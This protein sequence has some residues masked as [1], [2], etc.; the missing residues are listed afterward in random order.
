MVDSVLLEFM[1]IGILGIGSQW[2]SWRFRLPAIVVMSIAGLLAGPIFGLINPE[3]DFGDLYRPIISVAVAI[4]LFEGSLSL[5]FKEVRGLGRPVFRIVT[6]GALISWLLGSFA[7]HYVAGLS[8]AVAYVI[9]AIFIVTGPTVILPLLRQSK[10]KPRPAKILKW[11]GVIVDPFGALLAV[12]AFETILF[13]TSE[14]PDGTAFLLFFLAS[15]FAILLGL[16]FGKGTGWMFEAGYIPEFLKSPAVFAAVIACFTISDEIRHETGLLAVTAMGITLANMGISSI[17]DMRHF[18]ENI[19]IL[20][21]STIFIML[22]ASLTRDTLLDILNF[23]IIGYVLLMLF[24]VRP[25]SIF[26]STIGTDLTLKEKVLVGWIAPRGIVALTVAGYFASVLWEEGFED[27]RIVTSLTFALV[28]F[29]VCAHGFS[30][31]WLARKLDLSSEG[32]PGVLI[33]GSN[34]F[35][36]NLAK[37]FEELRVPTIITDSSW[38]RLATARRA[39]VN[40][41]HGEILSEQTEYHLDMTPYD[42][43]ISAT[44]YDSYNALVCTT[45]IPAFG[46]K[47]VFRLG[48]Q[49]ETG[50][51]VKEMVYTIGGRVLFAKNVALEDLI[52]KI[53][54][55]YV[56]RKTTITEQYNYDDYIK[57]RDDQAILLFIVKASKKIE[58]FIE[59]ITARAEQGDTVVSLTPPSKEFGKIQSKLKQQRNETNR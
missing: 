54:G 19:S 37:L 28:F 6:F 34:K 13:F 17:K 43:L 18:K 30:I 11:E 31:G 42:Y 7:A 20:L 44:E 52:Q 45:F 16:I 46:R 36:V 1:I 25:L 12:F 39:D 57:D 35:S 49:S 47:D 10:L 23:Q 50:D 53:E 58:F 32:Q 26:V 40:F 9:G 56:F 38:E 15:I 8:W 21:I 5:D 14:Q 51:N 41:H 29:T 48:I 27:A 4:I 2:L 24:I 59:D 22:T 55:G 3:Q 33:V